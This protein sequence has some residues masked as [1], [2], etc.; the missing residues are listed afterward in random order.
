MDTTNESSGKN[1]A[2]PENTSSK[3]N[4]KSDSQN[5]ASGLTGKTWLKIGIAGFLILFV[6]VFLSRNVLLGTPVEAYATQSTDLRQTVV[7]SGRVITP[8]RVS[9]AS[10]V[11]GRKIRRPDGW[12]ETKE[13]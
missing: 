4:P 7:A 13:L 3:N 1:T 10:K 6:I 2:A 5:R 8:Q 9:V 11:I 12:R